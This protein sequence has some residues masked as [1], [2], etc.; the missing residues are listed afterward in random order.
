MKTRT[1]GPIVRG[2]VKIGS[3]LMTD[4]F[5]IYPRIAGQDYSHEVVNHAAKEYVRGETHTNT[6][7][8]FWSH[9]KRGIKGIYIQV[10]RKHLNKYCKEFEFRYNTRKMSDYNRL[11]VS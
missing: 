10:C 3:T 6:I 8:G 5:K 11:V 9:L 4:E 2:N 1:V 7:G